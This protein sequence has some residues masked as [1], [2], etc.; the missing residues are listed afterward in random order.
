MT[1]RG[2]S[3]RMESEMKVSKEVEELVDNVLTTMLAKGLVEMLPDGSFQ[4]TEK[5]KKAADRRFERRALH[6]AS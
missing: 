3:K 2:F 4:L 6:D 5:G 1:V